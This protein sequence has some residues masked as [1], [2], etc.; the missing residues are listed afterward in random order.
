[1]E[2]KKIRLANGCIWCINAIFQ[3]LKGVKSVKPGY[4]GM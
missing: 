3:T 1:M 2:Y 4:I